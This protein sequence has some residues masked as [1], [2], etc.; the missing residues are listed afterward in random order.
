MPMQTHVSVAKAGVDALS[1]SV[2][3]EFGPVGVTSNV[4]SPGP[5]GETEVQ[6]KKQNCIEPFRS[7]GME[8]YADNFLRA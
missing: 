6:K 7:I 8:S 5:I 2:A 3:I 1:N 4:I